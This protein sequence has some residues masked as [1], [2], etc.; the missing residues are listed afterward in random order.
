MKYIIYFE[1]TEWEAHVLS[2]HF[3]K[4]DLELCSIDQWCSLMPDRKMERTIVLTCTDLGINAAK[5]K[6][7]PIL[8][9][10]NPVY[11]S[12]QGKQSLFGC[13]YLVESLEQVTE[14]LLDEVYCRSKGLPLYIGSTERCVVREMSQADIP[15]LF[16][17][18]NG[19]INEG[20]L[21]SEQMEYQQYEEF[22]KSYIQHMYG[23]YGYGIWVIESKDVIIGLAGFENAAYDFLKT[24]DFHLELSYWIHPQFRRR[25]YAYEICH[26][27]LE[28]VAK[29]NGWTPVSVFIKRE[30][31][32]SN[33]LMKKLNFLPCREY[34][35]EETNILQYKTD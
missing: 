20:S 13:A 5:N 18:T 26:Y 17:M 11:E 32:P 35:T 33:E 16:Q 6:D 21:H 7:F 19:W 34:I 2:E 28:V 29:E 15:I 8:A 3:Q 9:I 31:L 30:N 10:R 4:K 24:C 25:G 12:I 22:W 14:E 1:K 23:F 27:L